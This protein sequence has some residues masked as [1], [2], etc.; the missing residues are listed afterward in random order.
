[1]DLRAA[2]NKRGFSLIE[3]MIAMVFI[4][5]S[6][7]A[8]LTA[9]VTA[10]RTNQENELR[11]TAIRLTNQTAETLLALSF[12]KDTAEL[13]LTLDS[14][15]SRIAPA[16]SRTSGNTN[17]DAKG[18]PNPVQ[19]VRNAGVTYTI[20]WDVREQTANVREVTIAV[21]YPYRGQPRKNTSVIYKHKNL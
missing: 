18:F 15:G 14:A 11:N 5:I 3:M 13:S 20:E 6:M 2:F 10:E 4:M 12:E 19:T 1:M 7:L 17:Q 16:H 9:V 8:L 21:G